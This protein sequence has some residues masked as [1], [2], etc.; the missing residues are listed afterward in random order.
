MIHR[1]KYFKSYLN[2]FDALLVVAGSEIAVFLGRPN[3]LLTQAVLL[4]RDLQVWPTKVNLVRIINLARTLR[5]LRVLTA[6]QDLQR[7]LEAI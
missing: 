7:L 6:C 2:I 5:A 1:L 4:L 3:V